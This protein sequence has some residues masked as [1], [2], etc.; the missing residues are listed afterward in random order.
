MAEKIETTPEALA[1]GKPDLRIGED[2]EQRYGFKDPEQF[3]HKAPKGLT[4]RDLMRMS[5]GDTLACWNIDRERLFIYPPVDR[6][7]MLYLVGRGPYPR[8][9]IKDLQNA[10]DYER[11]MLEQGEGSLE[12]FHLYCGWDADLPDTSLNVCDAS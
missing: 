4:L 6:T 1:E 2:Y 5:E 9:F 12:H 3:F 7:M 11:G 10:C 8:A